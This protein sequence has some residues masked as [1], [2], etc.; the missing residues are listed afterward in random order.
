MSVQLSVDGFGRLLGIYVKGLCL[1]F[2]PDR[3]C[4]GNGIQKGWIVQDMLREIDRGS[5]IHKLD[6]SNL[7][8]TNRKQ[9]VPVLKGER[10]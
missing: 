7:A 9:F 5:L 10:Y 2:D 1:S 6:T 4:Y 8:W 3:H